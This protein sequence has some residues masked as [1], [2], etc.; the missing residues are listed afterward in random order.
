[1]I[2][3]VD[4]MLESFIGKD[5]IQEPLDQYDKMLS[6]AVTFDF[7][8]ITFSF[9]P[10]QVK[11]LDALVKSLEL[12]APD[13]L[14]V[15]GF[16]QCKAFVD[17]LSKYQRFTDVRNVG[18]AIYSMVQSAMTKMDECGFD[19]SG[20]WTYLTKVFGSNAIPVA[21]AETMKRAVKKAEKEG[22]VT[23]KNR[24]KLIEILC[25]RYINGT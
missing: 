19:D 14:G 9:L 15:A 12:S 22:L 7:K 16:G 6:P 3:D 21:E 24:W 1:M 23:S 18:A 8:N 13:I 5:I 11:D 20:E 2:E 25:D 10:H 17:T 4:D